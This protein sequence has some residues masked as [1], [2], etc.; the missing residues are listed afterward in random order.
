M[1]AIKI[2]TLNLGT[3]TE[4]GREIADLMERRK[5]E[6]LCVQ[7]TRWRVNKTRELGGSFKLIYSGADDRGRNGVGIVLSSDHKE[8]NINVT[9]KNDRIIAV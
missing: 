7:K 6:I 8:N 4:K 9:R 1:S 3:M 5:V 2:G